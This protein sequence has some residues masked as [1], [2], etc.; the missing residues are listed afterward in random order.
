MISSIRIVSLLVDRDGDHE[1]E[2]PSSSPGTVS[3][4]YVSLNANR[5]FEWAAVD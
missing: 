5:R 4:L 1:D 2:R 3:M